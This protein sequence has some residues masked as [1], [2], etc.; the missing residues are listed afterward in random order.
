MINRRTFNSTLDYTITN[1]ILPLNTKNQLNIDVGTFS[2][3]SL[4]ID[5]MIERLQKQRITEIEMSRGEFMLMKPP[6]PQMCES[7]RAKLDRAGIRCV[8][9]YTATIKTDEDLDYAVRYAKIFGAG[10]VSGDATG[11]ILQR[12]D[13]R[14]TRE[15]LT[16]GIH[17]HW[18]P[19]KFAYET[20]DDVLGGISGRSHAI[21][22]TLDV[23]QMAAC[24]QDPVDAVIRLG[25]YLKVV[26]LKDVEAAG[27]EHN[28]LLGQGIARIPEVMLALKKIGFK[29]LVAIEYEK[30]GDVDQDM[31]ME[32]EYARK[33]A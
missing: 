28:V 5:E 33:R 7:V 24:G 21:G 14:F 12:I 25:P 11:G 27:A 16:F 19:K 4:S 20:V 13:E 22:S 1:A 23:G 29:G 30:E 2:Y 18:F 17:N 9:Y 31:Q 10:N 26:H 32:I 8:S 15:R 3:H 6:T